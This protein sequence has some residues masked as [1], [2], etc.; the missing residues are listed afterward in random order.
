MT[1]IQEALDLLYV[2][3]KYDVQILV[4][5]LHYFFE[6]TMKLEDSVVVFQ[7]GRKYN[8]ERLWRFAFGMMAK[9]K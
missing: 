2:A 3:Q 6:R 1:G 4:N 7:A 5:K 9:A 8:H